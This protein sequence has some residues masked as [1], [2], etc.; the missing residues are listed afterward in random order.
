MKIRDE[1]NHY[2]A[3]K[4]ESG[5]VNYYWLNIARGAENH[6][7]DG[8]ELAICRLQDIDREIVVANMHTCRSRSGQR[9]ETRT[10]INIAGH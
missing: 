4:T 1:K 9:N 10:R 3:L 6:G 8:Q 7:I 2:A 5:K